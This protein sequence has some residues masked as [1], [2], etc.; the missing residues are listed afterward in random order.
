MNPSSR[1]PEGQ[2]NRC[3][4]CGKDLRIEPSRPPGDAPC[5]HCGQLIWFDDT[6]EPSLRDQAGR[7]HKLAEHAGKQMAKGNFDYAVELY[8]QCVLEDPSNAQ[9]ALAL[10]GAT[11]AVEKTL[12]N[13]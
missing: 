1:T 3:P 10:G 6:E 8:E 9:F 11:L 7:L 12:R 13:E 4:L 2:P 5:P